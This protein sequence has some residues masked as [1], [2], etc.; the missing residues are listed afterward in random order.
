ML[1]RSSLE[2]RL[3]AR[4]PAFLRRRLMVVETAI[5][6]SLAE[7]AAET[8]AGSRILDAGA[9]EGAH[10]SFFRHC[11][12]TSV[13]LGVGNTSW[14]Y[15]ELSAKA[16]LVALPFEDGAFDAAVNIVVLEHT[17]EPARVLKEIARVLRPGGRL[18][19]VAPQMWEVHQARH[20]YYRF[21]R[22]GLARLLAEAALSDPIIR[23]IGGYFTLLG[24]RT[25]NGLR[26]FQNGWRWLLFPLAAA[27]AGT[28]ALIL[29]L[30]DSLD[31]SKDF[32]LAY[33]C[34]ARK[35]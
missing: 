24:R 9:G 35:R 27:A 29:P 10:A 21:T 13:D 11:R 28:S 19:L 5:D 17:P 12:Y 14:D 18:L 6:D 7:F 34:F 15:S 16:N 26:F 2:R 22:H 8:A 3:A 4:L 25:L 20:N 31:T 23:P 1:E 33:V 32:T 30:F